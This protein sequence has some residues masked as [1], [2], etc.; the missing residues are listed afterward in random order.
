MVGPIIDELSKKYD[1]RI[2]FYKVNCDEE[3]ELA[4]V[5]GIQSIP[6][7]LIIP[8]DGTP[9]MAIGALPM[10]EFE[11]IISQELLTTNPLLAG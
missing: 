8:K 7:L 4:G 11:R 1:G 5:F 10:A 3:Q 9:K 2:N 6:S